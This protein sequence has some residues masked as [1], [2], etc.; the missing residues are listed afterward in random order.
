MRNVVAGD[1]WWVTRVA[2][3]TSLVALFFLAACG[4]KAL[5]GQEYRQALKVD[6]SALTIVVEGTKNA[7][8]VTTAT[9]PRRYSEL[10]EAEIADGVNPAGVHS[11]KRFRLQINFVEDEAVQFVK[12]DGT[13]SRGD[14][15]YTSNYTVIR[16]AD[17]VA[18]ADGNIQRISSYNTS[19]TADYASYVSLEDARKR[20]ITEL[21]QD[22]KLRLAALLPVMNDP[23]AGERKA[24]P[25]EAIPELKPV[26]YDE[27]GRAR[28]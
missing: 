7:V 4:F 27:T 17:M 16:L 12:P 21:A 6:L 13:A 11:E 14:L 19:P 8:G 18:V 22:Y 23:K 1:G 24:A 25:T 15:V 3:R 20:G 9:I 28:Y 26:R 5:H 2:R 10:L